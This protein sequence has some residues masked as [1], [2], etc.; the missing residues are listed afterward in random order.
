LDITFEGAEVL[1]MRAATDRLAR[2]FGRQAF[3]NDPA[4]YHSARPGYPDWVYDTL[5]SRCGLRGGAAVFEIGAGTGTATRRLLELGAD[6]LV[7]VEP[8]RRL[9][10]FLRAN[11]PDQALTVM[12]SPFEEVALERGAFDLGVSATAFHWLDEAS[13]LAKIANLLRSGGWWVAV[14]N[15]FGDDTRPDPFH[16][17]TKKLLEAPSSPSAGERGVPFAL[18]FEARLAA[19]NRSGDFDLMETKTSRWSLVLDAEQTV[20]LYATY[21]NVNAR[22]DRDAVLAELGRIA[23]EQ[24]ENRV[25]RNMMTSLFIGR[26]AG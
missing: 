23:R 21:S 22:S 14:W 6:P 20:A 10:D 26:R 3:G 18:D 13:A 11:N 19:L 17:A 8:D 16:E 12:V 24:F 9:A 15:E 5:T 25:V 4:G 2:E 1:R 7:A